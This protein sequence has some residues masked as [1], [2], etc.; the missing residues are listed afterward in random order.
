MAE[1]FKFWTHGTAVIPEYTKSLTGHNNGLHLRPTG[2]GS[3]V[4]Q[5][6]DTSNWFH[7]AIPSPSRLDDW[8]SYR[9]HAWLRARIGNCAVIDAVNIHEASGPDSRSPRIYESGRL[10]WTGRNQEFSFNLNDRKCRGPLVMSV[11][12]RFETGTKQ[13]RTIWF[14]GAGARFEEKS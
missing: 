13:H 1:E 14:A 4:W 7:F 9:Y 5:K 6:A 8:S 11:H 2:Y 3:E 10:N 12:A